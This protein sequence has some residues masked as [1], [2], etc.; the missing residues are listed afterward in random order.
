MPHSDGT[1][2]MGQGAMTGKNR[3]CCARASNDPCL[4]LRGRNFCG[5]GNGRRHRNCFNTTGLSGW[6]R[7]RKGMQAF[8]NVSPRDT[9]GTAK[10][11]ETKNA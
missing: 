7:A 6:I 5:R 1:G 9:S 10:A 3:G 4:T 2:P 8:G 11:D